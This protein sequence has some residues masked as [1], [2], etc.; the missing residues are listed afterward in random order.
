MA[1]LKLGIRTRINGGFGVLV[2][3]SLG[4]TGFGFWQLLQI[5]GQVARMS[6]LSDLNTRASEIGDSFEVIRFAMLRFRAFG[7]EAALHQ[8]ADAE[9]HAGELLAASRDSIASDVRKRAYDGLQGALVGLR[10]NRETLAAAAKQ[11][12]ADRAKLNTVGEEL[13]D[14]VAKVVEA[15]LATGD[16]MASSAAN[17]LERS[18]QLVRVGIWRFLATKD[19]SALDLIRRNL[20]RAGAGLTALGAAEPPEAIRAQIAPVRAALASYTATFES[21]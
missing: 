4:I 5:D 6:R 12:Q 21:L 3:L 2:A 10:A 13:T 17:R 8:A 14:N 9:V 18:F 11:M 15:A 16:Q 20:P 19:P 1:S 7:D